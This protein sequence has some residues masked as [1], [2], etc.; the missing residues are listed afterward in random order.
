MHYLALQSASF[1]KD[2]AR[3]RLLI[4]ISCRCWQVLPLPLRSQAGVGI[5]ASAA[6]EGGHRTW[7]PGQRG[8]NQSG[9]VPSSGVLQSTA[10][11]SRA[12][13]RA[14]CPPSRTLQACTGVLL[15][16]LPILSPLTSVFLSLYSPFSHLTGDRLV[17]RLL[18]AGRER[19]A[20]RLTEGLQ[21]EY[22]VLNNEGKTALLLLGKTSLTNT[23]T[24]VF[25]SAWLL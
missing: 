12:W 5:P 20:N 1:C 10:L 11:C 2:P 17:Q 13:A 6:A 4:T 25:G 14:C 3:L 16:S 8:S 23:G 19:R 18:M 24:S 21:Q 22:S 7:G 15:P 9:A